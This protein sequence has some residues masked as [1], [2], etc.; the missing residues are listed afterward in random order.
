MTGYNVVFVPKIKAWG[1]KIVANFPTKEEAEIRA[2]WEMALQT[3]MNGRFFGAFGKGSK[4]V[5]RKAR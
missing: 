5:V 1:E 4:Y 2:K 3:T